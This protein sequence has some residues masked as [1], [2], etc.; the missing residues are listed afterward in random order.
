[1]P[2]EKGSAIGDIL[3]TGH[4]PAMFDPKGVAHFFSRS[5][6]LVV[7]TYQGK[8]CWYRFLEPQPYPEDLRTD[9]VRGDF[10]SRACL[11]SLPDRSAIKKPGS[12]SIFDKMG[13]SH[14]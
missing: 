4:P 13:G 14:F 2:D 1:M 8:P 7:S 6:V 9:D 12:T 10:L 11:N 5:Q 3:L